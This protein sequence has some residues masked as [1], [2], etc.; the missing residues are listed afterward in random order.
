MALVLQEPQTSLNPVLCVG[1][2]IAETIRAHRGVDGHEA[3]R[4]AVALLEEMQI[5]GAEDKAACFPHQLSGGM[6]QRVL[7]AAA[8][9]CDPKLLI[10]DEPTTALDVT[11]QR[12]ILALIRRIRRDR[13]MALLFITHDADLVPLVATSRA[14]MASG[15]ITALVDLDQDDPEEGDPLSTGVVDAGDQ[16]GGFRDQVQSVL[17]ARGLYAGYGVTAGGKESAARW[18]L[19]AVT[20]VDV[21][22]FAGQALGIAG[23]SGCGKT[24]L[25][26]VLSRHLVPVAGSVELAGEDFLAARGDCLRKRRRLV[27]LLFQDPAGSL[28]PRQL[29]G[30][31]VREAADTRHEDLAAALLAEVGLPPEMEFR[32]PHEL[33]GGQRQRVALARCLAA[34]PR[35]LIADEPTSALDVDSR[36]RILTLL[37]RAREKR[38]LALMVISH[39]LPILHAVCDRVAIMYRGMV[40]ESYPVGDRVTAL[41]PYTQ[42]LTA[43]SPGFLKRNPRWWVDTG[44]VSGDVLPYS[45]SGC[46]LVG[47]CPLQKSHCSKELPSLQE[48]GPGHFLRCPES[49]QGG[50][51]Q[52]IDT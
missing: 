30:D 7:L 43:A 18:P 44:Q 33:S 16:A 22:L 51:S 19:V 4:R 50:S 47:R 21:D 8:M 46:P 36:N 39:D 35:V 31:L 32:Y 28:N 40:V 14:E 2:Q 25:A 15:R 20:D 29:V 3:R 52:F 45:P 6:R 49:T 34:E 48:V 10:A 24:T 12:E 11:V 17:K 38:G 27:Q 23:E 1:D 26:R 9:A 37:R 41:H 42:A 13:E 5:Q